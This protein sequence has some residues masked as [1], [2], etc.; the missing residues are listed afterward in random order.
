M[1]RY[2]RSGF[3]RSPFDRARFDQSR[4]DRSSEDPQLRMSDAEREQAATDLGEHYAQGR[5][6]TEEHSERL[7]RIWAARTR[8]ELGPIFSDLPTGATAPRAAAPGPARP[9][10]RFRGI[11][12]PLL[13]L[14]GILIAV[15]V[16]TNLP[17][18]LIGLAIWFVLA[19]GVCGGRAHQRW[20]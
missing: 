13:V 7:D 15:T 19:R 8:G 14:L 3:D 20:R 10:P 11:P 9:R 2:D 18:I 1:T 17:W 6:T 5:L 16:V 12:F 4:F